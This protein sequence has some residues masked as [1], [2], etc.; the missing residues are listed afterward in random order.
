MDSTGLEL[1]GFLR[2]E[3]LKGVNYIQ[4]DQGIDN[5]ELSPRRGLG[6]MI[7]EQYGMQM[8]H[9]LFMP[10]SIGGDILTPDYIDDDHLA[11][12][13]VS[14]NA[15]GQGAIVERIEDTTNSPTHVHAG[16]RGTSVKFKLQSSM[17]VQTSSFLFERLG[18]TMTLPN[19]GT[20]TTTLYYIDSQI[21]LYGVKTGR[22]IDIPIRLIKYKS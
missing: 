1:A 6:E 22:S 21:R 2:G 12:Y 16:P 18:G 5:K 17:D 11:Y 20:G 14:V 4:V 7:E 3:T 13:T 19:R 15:T 9:R 10:T 8:D